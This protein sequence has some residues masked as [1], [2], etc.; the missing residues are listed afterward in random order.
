[1]AN[2]MQIMFDTVLKNMG[3]D[4]AKLQ[5]NVK[6]IFERFVAL[7]KKVEGEVDERVTSLEAE[8]RMLKEHLALSDE[9]ETIVAEPAPTAQLSLEH[10]TTEHVGA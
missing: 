1:M 4:P 6:G 9:H 3:V 8:V 7:E 2:A 5:E 10:S